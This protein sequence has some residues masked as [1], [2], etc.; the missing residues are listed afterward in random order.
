MVAGCVGKRACARPLARARMRALQMQACW[1]LGV[2]PWEAAAHARGEHCG[3]WSAAPR[4][5][6]ES[7]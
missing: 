2:L 5:H 4:R 7:L 6:F 1:G 3:T